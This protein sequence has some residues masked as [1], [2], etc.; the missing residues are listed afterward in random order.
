MKKIILLIALICISNFSFTQSSN[1]E[2]NNRLNLRGPSK[3]VDDKFGKYKSYSLK[4]NL[5][6]NL[7]KNMNRMK[8]AYSTEYL[9]RLFVISGL[10]K[11]DD[12]D[13][14]VKY[15]LTRFE[16]VEDEYVEK[17]Y[18]KAPAYYIGVESNVEILDKNGNLIYKRFY[19][20]KVKMYVIN[21]DGSFEN[22][23]YRILYNNF[24]S[25]I[26]EFDAFYLYGPA[27][28]NLRYF[29]IEK[30]KKSKSQFNIEEFNQSV[31]VLPSLV[32]VDRENWAELF[33]EAQK[34]WKG[35]VNYEDK[36]DDDLQEDIRFT[37]NY[38][39]AATHILLGQTEEAST[40][41]QG[42]KE[43]E[44]SFLGMRDHYPY[45]KGLIDNIPKYVK[46]TDKATTL[47]PIQ[48]EPI[49]ATYKKSANAFHFAE[50]DGEVLDSDQ[51]IY[52]GKIR[53]ISDSPELVDYRTV[54]T[55]S[56]LRAAM[57]VVGAD[58]SSVRIY[59]EGQKKPEKTNLKKVVNIK[60]NEG[61][62]Y[63]TGKTGNSFSLSEENIGSRRFAL[64]E[65]I[66]KG[67]K[68]SV[69]KEFFPQDAFV[70]KKT[71]E[72][73]FY[74]PPILIGRKKSLKAYF[75][76]CPEMIANIDK[77]LYNFENKETYLKMFDDYSKLCG[78]K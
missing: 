64:F 29:E 27:I 17:S 45:M 61:H 67:A 35:F 26:E 16:L 7:E 70:L 1:K 10:K 42:I 78:N 14:K 25:L 77:G 73:N 22:L 36:K 55:V 62:I 51:K 21:P 63:L 57:D 43:N 58:K 41:L 47:M 59:I 39:L 38:N 65:E 68:I 5:D 23:V 54:Q 71:T 8:A 24:Y 19:S 74:T 60:D 33:G 20:P 11:I 49:L 66:K 53:I 6:V 12:G 52:K 13:F 2:K 75:A 76:D 3:P 32:D 40:Y 4:L 56:A 30:R 72:D 9:N 50:F 69:Y 28:E 34:Y 37:A 48:E 46:S 31:Q 18:Q 15:N 44:K